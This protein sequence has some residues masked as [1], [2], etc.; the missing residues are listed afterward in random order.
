MFTCREIAVATGGELRGADLQVTGVTTD[1]RRIKPGELFVAL[2][3]ERFDGHDFIPAVIVAG[4]RAVIADQ[5]WA[6]SQ[7]AATGDS[8]IVV[9][10]TLRALGDLAAAHRR[11]FVLPVIGVT[12]SNGKTTVKEMLAGILGQT[13]ECLK[14][15]GNLNNLIGLPQMLLRLTAAHHWAVLEMGMSELGEIDRLAEIAAPGVGIITNVNAAHL[16][17]MQSVEMVA[18][19]KGELFQRLAPGAWAVYN[20]DDPR[21]A[22]CPVPA[23]V[24]RLG[25]GLAAG[26]VTARNLVAVGAAGQRF[27]LVLPDGELGVQ[28]PV[29]GRHN[30]MDALAAAAA[31]WTV[32]VPGGMI[33]KG[34]HDFVP[35]RQ[36]FNLLEVGGVTVVDDT[37]NANP[38]SM[39]AAL[40]TF[41]ECAAGARR[42]AVLGEM[43]ELGTDEVQLHREVGSQAATTVQ[44]LIVLGELGREIA[45]GA[46]SA[47][48]AAEAV[49]WVATHE[50]AV[51]LV[52]S[53]L[54]PGEWLLVKG[55]R[56]MTMERIVDGVRARLAALN[57]K[58]A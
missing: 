13:G 9:A 37:Y 53:E 56:G 28:L 22:G 11:R 58:G 4:A 46:R 5:A 55:S 15:E 8:V 38:A 54:S 27:T 26:E 33:A 29:P 36:R 45:A 2:R 48:L 39:A 52:I 32:G 51:E 16:A 1:S 19:A 34:L 43:R 25:F 47:G 21:V 24:S 40:A 44:R 6:K 17:S 18:R 14:T 42:T 31:A 57:G 35:Y 3:G 20:A 41:A 23:G 12:G 30:L 10:D 7:G 49:Q 50:E